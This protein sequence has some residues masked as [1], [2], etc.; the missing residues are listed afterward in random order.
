MSFFVWCELVCSNCSSTTAGNFTKS[1]R[2]RQGAMLRAATRSGWKWVALEDGREDW[3]CP[4][5]LSK[6]SA[7]TTK[8]AK[9]S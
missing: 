9:E 4:E 3:L 7:D 2:I 1:G 8:Q 5:C 6:R